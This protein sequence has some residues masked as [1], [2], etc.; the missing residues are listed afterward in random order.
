[1]PILFN[2]TKE[3]KSIGHVTS[4]TY[5]LE[6]GATYTVPVHDHEDIG[7]FSLIRLMESSNIKEVTITIKKD[8]AQ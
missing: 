2:H 1:M 7:T 4:L 5:V 6:N 8:D 3:T